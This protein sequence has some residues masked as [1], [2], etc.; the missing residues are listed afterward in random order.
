[1][2]DLRSPSRKLTPRVRDIL[3]TLEESSSSSNIF[4]DLLLEI[5]RRPDSGAF[6]T[7]ELTGVSTA[8]LQQDL[9]RMFVTAAKCATEE[10][11]EQR[12]AALRQLIEIAQSESSD[13]HLN[14][15]GS[16]IILLAVAR[17]KRPP[18]IEV[19]EKYGL[20]LEKLRVAVKRL[21][22]GT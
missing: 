4:I 13:M 17:V 18:L 2:N 16:E 1:M 10:N 20:D 21:L 8:I 7:I 9:N 14:Y 15:I 19:L 3:F 11:L 12:K 22:H 5:L 6:Q